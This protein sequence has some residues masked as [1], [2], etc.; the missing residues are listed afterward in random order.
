[1]TLKVEGVVVVALE[2]ESCCNGRSWRWGVVAVENGKMS[3]Q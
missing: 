3:V 2:V 1:V